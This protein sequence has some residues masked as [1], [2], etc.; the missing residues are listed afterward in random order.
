MPIYLSSMP[1]YQSLLSFSLSNYP[2]GCGV[3]GLGS[4]E[5]RLSIP[6][7]VSQLSG[8]ESLGSRLGTR[9]GDETSQYIIE[10]QY[11]DIY[12][13]FSCRI[14]TEM[15]FQRLQLKIHYVPRSLAEPDSHTKSGGVWL[16]ETM[17]TARRR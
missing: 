6:D 16:R 5:P 3:E 13:D 15:I 12:R 4:L 11:K 2:T 7:F 9:S 14:S 1:V 17:S 10:Y 8:T